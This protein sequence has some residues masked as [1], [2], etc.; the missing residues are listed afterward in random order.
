MLRDLP[1][2][3]ALAHLLEVEEMLPDTVDL[4][5]G[6]RSLTWTRPSEL[7]DRTRERIY[8][9]LVPVSSWAFGADMTPYWRDRRAGGYLKRIS[10]FTVV[11][12]SEDRFVGWTGFH[13]IDGPVP[14]LYVDSTGVVP[15]YQ[16]AGVMRQIF[17]ARLNA[18]LDAEA[19]PAMV[20]ARSESP[21]FYLLL[22][23]LFGREHV[24]PQPAR[25]APLAVRE[26]AARLAE[27]LG[28]TDIFDPDTQ[29]VVGAYDNLDALY[30]D[31]PSCGDADLDEFFRASLG[32]L[33]AY[34]MVAEGRPGDDHAA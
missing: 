5:S 1:K 8:S 19:G 12:D 11:V 3:A 21:I 2:E 13:R 28:Q 17:R 10:E 16:S 14:N 27:W 31:L 7:D 18:A 9:A 23:S 6:L 32:P 24:F 20:S 4:G 15:P 22:A 34:L 26:T 30:G 33:D 29:R 25:E